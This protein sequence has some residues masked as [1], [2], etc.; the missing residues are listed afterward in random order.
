[1]GRRFS[2]QILLPVEGYEEDKV[3]KSDDISLKVANLDQKLDDVYYRRLKEKSVYAS[4]GDIVKFACQKYSLGEIHDFSMHTDYF[5]DCEIE[6]EGN[7]Y[8][9]IEDEIKQLKREYC[10]KT[11]CCSLR[12]FYTSIGD[13]IVLENMA[14]VDDEL[15][16]KL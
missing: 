3:Y 15:I 5:G 6:Y 14:I 12:W 7:R 13:E 4:F 8:V 1:M 11:E 2:L 16:Q 9:V 10:N